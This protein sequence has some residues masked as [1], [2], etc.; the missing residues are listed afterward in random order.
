MGTSRCEQPPDHVLI[1]AAMTVCLRCVRFSECT[2][3][4]VCV[5]VVC[6]IYAVFGIKEGITGHKMHILH[7]MKTV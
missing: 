2:L 3:V 6:V 5:C 1:R 4:G 7:E